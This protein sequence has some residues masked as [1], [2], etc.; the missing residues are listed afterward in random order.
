MGP[1]AVIYWNSQF[2]NS[3]DESKLSTTIYD[4]PPGLP[5]FMPT[6]EKPRVLSQTKFEFTLIKP[7]TQGYVE[8][9]GDEHPFS[10]EELADHALASLAFRKFSEVPV[11]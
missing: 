5:G 10:V 6:F 11:D 3:L 7:E 8:L 2:A 9:G 4:G 1:A